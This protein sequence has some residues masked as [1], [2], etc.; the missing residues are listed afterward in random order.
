MLPAQFC[1]ST[2]Q[3]AFIMCQKW[4][5]NLIQMFSANGILNILATAKNTDWY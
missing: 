5:D 1:S 2:S 4:S 3:Q